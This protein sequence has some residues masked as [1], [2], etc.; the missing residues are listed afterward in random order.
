MG[1]LRRRVEE[2]V[3]KKKQD[4]PLKTLFRKMGL[5]AQM[6][7]KIYE[8]LP[9]EGELGHV[10]TVQPKVL[11]TAAEPRAQTSDSDSS[12]T[13]SL[14]ID[15]SY[16]SEE[17]RSPVDTSSSLPSP[18]VFREE[19]YGCTA[20]KGDRDRV[21]HG[22]FRLDEELTDLLLP[23]KNSTLLDLSHA[24]TI[25][26]HQPPN[27]ST[28]MDAPTVLAEISLQENR[29]PS[30]NDELVKD[31]SKREST[32][33]PKQKSEETVRAPPSSPHRDVEPDTETPNGKQNLDSDE[34]GVFFDFGSDAE[35]DSYFCRMRERCLKLKNAAVFPLTTAKLKN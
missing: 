22:T 31:K 33:S 5:K 28:I 23:I 11:E 8:A 27:L 2:L 35:H 15:T 18:E 7:K 10:Q 14:V 13:Q 16:T 34:G 1:R 6:G 17:Q 19:Q 3:R 24:E 4:T 30:V 21:E 29:K 20:K 9:E 32:S 12:S 25:L 26:M